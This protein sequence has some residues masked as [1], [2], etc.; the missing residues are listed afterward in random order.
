MLIYLKD[1]ASS[2][3]VCFSYQLDSN[4]WYWKETPRRLLEGDWT[5]SLQWRCTQSASVSLP[6]SPCFLTFNYFLLEDPLGRLYN[7]NYFIRLGGK[8][9]NFIPQSWVTNCLSLRKMLVPFGLYPSIFQKESLFFSASTPHAGCNGNAGSLL[10]LRAPPYFGEPL[11]EKGSQV[12]CFG[13]ATLQPDSLSRPQPGQSAIPGLAQRWSHDPKWANGNQA[14]SPWGVA[15]L[16]EGCPDLLA[17]ILLPQGRSLAVNEKKT[18]KSKAQK[19]KKRRD[20][21]W[22]GWG[23]GI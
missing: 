23:S 11:G 9:H 6:Q 10:F 3:R 13:G 7:Q 22:G 16:P 2:S 8:N 1:S 18:K 12:T 20:F 14:Q 15:G 5:S 4:P 19:W 17:A 21:W